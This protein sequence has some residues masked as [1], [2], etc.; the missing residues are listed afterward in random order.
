M[1]STI[2]GMFC[3]PF[4]LNPRKC[5]R[6]LQLPYGFVL[7]VS[8]LQCTTIDVDVYL[9]ERGVRLPPQSLLY[10]RLP[11]KQNDMMINPSVSKFPLD[12]TTFSVF[13][14]FA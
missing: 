1:W 14:Y 5:Y 3:T 10:L 9:D 7:D 6:W 12:Y 11:T 2:R 4:S 13:L 8:L